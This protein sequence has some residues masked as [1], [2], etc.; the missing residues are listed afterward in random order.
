MCAVEIDKPVSAGSSRLSNFD[1]LNSTGE[2]NPGAMSS[3]PYVLKIGADADDAR[4]DAATG[5]A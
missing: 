3:A 5:F 1:Y 2:E 4:A